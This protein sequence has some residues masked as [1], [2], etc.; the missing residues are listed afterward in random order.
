MSVRPKSWHWFQRLLHWSMAGVL[1]YLLAIG[2]WGSR[3]LDDTDPEQLLEKFSLIQTHKSW[4]ALLLFLWVLRVAWRA[5][6]RPPAVSSP[7]ARAVHLAMYV[8]MFALPVTGWLMAS[9]SPL[10]DTWGLKNMVFGVF[11]MPDPFD[12]GSESLAETLKLAHGAVAALLSVLVVGHIAAA[13]WHGLIMRDGVLKRM[14][15]GDRQATFDAQLRSP[16]NH[17]VAVTDRQGGRS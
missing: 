9:A 11:E 15:L 5:L 14:M 3:V 1:L 6:T 8:L 7:V 2:V 12:P 13:L 16:N 17:I 10:Q 4:G